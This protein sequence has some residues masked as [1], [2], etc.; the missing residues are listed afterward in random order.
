MRKIPQTNSSLALEIIPKEEK[1]NE[2]LNSQIRISYRDIE[3]DGRGDEEEEGGIVGMANRVI[4][5]AQEAQSNR[6]RRRFVDPRAESAALQDPRRGQEG[7][8]LDSRC[9]IPSR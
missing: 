2:T 7:Q 9:R 5:H 1:K 4:D 8:G 6:R 3:Y